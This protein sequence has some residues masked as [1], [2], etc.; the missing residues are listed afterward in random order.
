MTDAEIE[1][2]FRSMACKLMDDAQTDKLMKA[3]YG[4]EQ[5]DDIGRLMRLLKF[6]Q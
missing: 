4:L 6:R 2:K 3:I 1:D 5:L